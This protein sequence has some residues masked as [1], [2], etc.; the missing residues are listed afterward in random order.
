MN[1][2][3]IDL[4]YRNVELLLT[5]VRAA[6][7]VNARTSFRR[8]PAAT[9]ER[10]L[11]REEFAFLVYVEGR[12]AWIA[13]H[14]S[15]DVPQ[16]VRVFGEIV[17]FATAAEKLAKLPE[18]RAAYEDAHRVRFAEKRREREMRASEEG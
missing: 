14:G 4:A 8:D 2:S 17:P 12:E 3:P 10:M 13:I 11:H 1:E 7:N 9:A 18:T 16:M 15:R 5:T 6:R